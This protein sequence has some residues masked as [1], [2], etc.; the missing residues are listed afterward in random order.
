MT[1]FYDVKLIYIR[2]AFKTRK[3][4]EYAGKMLETL[5]T[6]RAKR[7]W[8]RDRTRHPSTGVVLR[9][10]YLQSCNNHRSSGFCHC[11]RDV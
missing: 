5:L 4:D 2:E 8:C 9:C 10:H 3:P 6:E 7:E 1:E 11:V